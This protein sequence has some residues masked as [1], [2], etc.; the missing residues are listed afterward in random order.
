MFR[1]SRLRL[2][3]ALIVCFFSPLLLRGQDSAAS[4][5]RA[6]AQKLYA[7]H[8]AVCHGAEAHGGEY[9]PPLVGN[10]GLQGK[11]LA[12]I[13]DVIHHGIPSGGMPAFDLPGTELDDLASLVMSFNQPAGKI[14]LAGNPSQGEQYFFGAGRCSS[15]HMV[16]GRGSAIGPDLLSV[17]RELTAEQMREALVEPSARLA[18]GYT[19]V[20]VRLRNGQLL[21]GFARS[22]SSF[23]TVLQDSQGQSH[24]LANDE[25][26]SLQ[27]DSQ[28]PMPAVAATPEQLQDLLAY[29][30][31]LT[32]VKP[33]A[34]APS[35]N[36]ADETAPG[37]I[38]FARVLSPGR[39]DW[40][41]YNG[42][43]AGNRYSNLA[44][45]HAGNIAHLQLQWIYTVPL[46]RQSFPDSAYYKENLHIMG[47]R[48]R[49]WWPTGSCMPPGRSRHTHSTPVRVSPSGATRASGRREWWAMRPLLPTA[50]WRSLETSFSW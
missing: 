27:E 43:L 8:C 39:G 30:S 21:H 50:V 33:G 5:S 36:A 7:T 13:H 3:A 23:E 14:P 40:L 37:G 41:S 10:S 35:A 20:T 17:A 12:W 11:P 49:P 45:I 47:W 6:Q 48:Q 4:Q 2:V 46:W 18:P 16:N 22:R 25:I 42:G 26:R 34:G 9:G 24:L 31:G 29:L 1:A 15:C 28:S 44:G 38:P 32:G 19:P